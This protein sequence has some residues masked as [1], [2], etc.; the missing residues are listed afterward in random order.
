MQVQRDERGLCLIVIRCIHS[1]ATEHKVEVPCCSTDV[2]Y[3]YTNSP[4]DVLVWH[5]ARRRVK[6]WG[7]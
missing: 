7:G 2:T 4:H 3:L 6:I 1:A 5:R